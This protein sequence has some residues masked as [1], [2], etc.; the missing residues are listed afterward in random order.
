M[1]TSLLVGLDGSPMAEVALSQAIIVGQRFR[2]RL[3]IAHV[4]PP[5]GNTGEMALG[6]PWMEWT[7]ES[8][9]ST[10][11][12]HEMATRTMLEDA[13]GA[14][15]RAGLD[16]ETVWRDGMVV[17]VLRELAEQV[18]VV[19]VGRVGLRGASDPLGPD[20]RELI[21]RC[22]R[23]VLVTGRAPT[24]MERVL[25]AYDGSPASE[26]ALD[27]AARFAAIGGAHVDVL[28]VAQD[29]NEGQRLLARAS[30]ALSLSMLSFETHFVTGDFEPA[31][32]ATVERLG[33]DTLFVG[34]HRE[35]SGWLVPSHTEAIL[36]ATDL[37]VLVHT[38][39]STPSARTSSASHRRPAS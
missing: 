37:P 19:L 27:F 13:A 25:L 22:P 8:V 34:A 21:R 28:H 32:A 12:E 30:S 10:R 16:V 9:P 35:E 39:P 7:P 3:L 24:S 14:A 36:R 29:A 15:R 18:G 4:S 38:Q 1:F 23:P 11:R 2:A 6:A 20:T 33:S 17:D 31:V 5:P 26:A